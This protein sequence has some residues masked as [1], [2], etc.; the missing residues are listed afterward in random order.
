MDFA[1]AT[2]GSIFL[3]LNWLARPFVGYGGPAIAAGLHAA[4]S[5]LVLSAH[6]PMVWTYRHDGLAIHADVVLGAV[7][8]RVPDQWIVVACH[9]T[10]HDTTE[11]GV[12][13]E[14]TATQ[15]MARNDS[16]DGS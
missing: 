11:Y 7:D 4:L 12:A 3:F 6:A 5:G 2:A 15:G 16:R 10:P 9:M 13:W 1:G 8:G 14:D